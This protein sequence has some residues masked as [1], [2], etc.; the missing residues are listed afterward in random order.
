MQNT[1]LAAW[2]PLFKEAGVKQIINASPLSMGL[3]RTGEAPYWHPAPPQLRRANEEVVK[4]LADR[5]VKLEDVALG[6][7]FAS[8]AL[9]DGD[10]PTPTVVGLS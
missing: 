5:G 2:Y 3:L 4:T 7:G 9:K 1:S 8:A 10:L 6:F